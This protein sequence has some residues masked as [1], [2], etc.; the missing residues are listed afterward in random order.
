MSKNTDQVAGR[1]KQAAGDLTDDQDLAKE[2][3]RQEAAGKVKEAA[4]QVK[5]S[6]DHAVD[7]VKDSMNDR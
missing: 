4:D 6:F 2:G 1:I 3:R 7:K 5:D